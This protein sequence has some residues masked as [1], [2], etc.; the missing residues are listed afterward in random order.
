MTK[1]DWVAMTDAQ[2]QKLNLKF[3]K[4]VPTDSRYVTSADG[5][6]EKNCTQDA[7][8]DRRKEKDGDNNEK[9]EKKRR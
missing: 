2:Q 3:R 6:T 4:F 8:R 5:Q 1:M 9:Q 7:N